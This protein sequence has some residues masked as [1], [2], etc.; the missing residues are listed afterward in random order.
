MCAVDAVNMCASIRTN[1]LPASSLSLSLTHS[2]SLST[3]ISLSLYLYLSHT[4]RTDADSEADEFLSRPYVIRAVTK[5]GIPDSAVYSNREEERERERER[6]RLPT[7]CCYWS[8]LDLI[9]RH[10]MHFR[11]CTRAR[12]TT[13]YGVI[14]ASGVTS[15]PRN[16]R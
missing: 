4:T 9:R 16:R 10:C 5:R 6:D 7:R 2:L 14:L 11:R 15:R 13:R 3:S 8:R 1:S 12:I